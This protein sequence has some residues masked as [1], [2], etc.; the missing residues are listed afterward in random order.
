MLL[1]GCCGVAAIA[2]NSDQQR[3]F[4]P[5][6]GE[7]DHESVFVASE[8]L[9]SIETDV[10]G[11]NGEPTRVRCAT[12]HAMVDT[13]KPPREAADLTEFHRG[14]SVEHGDLA[15]ASC[16]EPNEPLKLRLANGDTIPVTDAIRLCSQCHGPQRKSYDS[17]AHGGMNGHWD[18]SR[19]DRTRN[20]C[21][22]CHDPHV[23]A[24]PAV[25]P[26]LP[27]VDRGEVTV[28]EHR[29]DGDEERKHP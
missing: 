21:V 1:V 22:D 26:V 2:C 29:P 12:C 5:A 15:C 27:P 18:L 7:P 6:P 14:L 20:Q 19:G 17:G 8:R 11:P 13:G 25:E 4:E 24:I 3:P 9:E 16:H 23:P 10:L 28:S